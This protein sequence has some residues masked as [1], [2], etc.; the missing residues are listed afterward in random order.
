MRTQNYFRLVSTLTI[1]INLFVGIGALYLIERIVPAIDE[2]LNENA[3]SISAAVSMQ[4][5]LNLTTEKDSIDTEDIFWSAFSKANNNVTIEGEQK[6][7]DEIKPLA[8][9]YWAGEHEVTKLLSKKLVELSELNL[10]AMETKNT[11]AKSYNT[12]ATGR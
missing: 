1:A 7:L 5:S 2:V 4:E 12:T 3:Y 8:E 10:K 9:R 6:I 11:M